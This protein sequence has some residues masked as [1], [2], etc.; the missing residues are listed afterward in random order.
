[1]VEDAWKM[2]FLEE[3]QR[4]YLK[5]WHGNLPRA[6]SGKRPQ[7][8]IRS[9]ARE[10]RT[11]YILAMEPDPYLSRPQ[12]P[13]DLPGKRHGRFIGDF[14]AARAICSHKPVFPI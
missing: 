1:M 13:R 11:A 10:E 14:T 9:R 5:T 4:A 2:S 7:E 3:R 12:W 8:E 6:E